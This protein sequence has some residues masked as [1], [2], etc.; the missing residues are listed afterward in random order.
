M[1]EVFLGFARTLRHAGVPATPDRVQ[2]ML[3]ALDVLHVTEPA[4]VYWA[5]RLTLCGEPDDLPIYDAAFAAYFGG[6][7]PT[8]G[9]SL[10]MNPTLPRVS[11][12]FAA[13]TG[14]GDDE[15]AEVLTLS[16]SPP[17]VLRHRDV[18]ELSTVERAEGRRLPALPAPLTAPRRSRRYRP[19]RRGAVDAHRTGRQA[20]RPEGEPARPDRSGPIPNPHRQGH[21][22]GRPLRT[23]S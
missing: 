19:A 23:A 17:A 18:A 4:D 1:I 22:T 8:A 12:P 2:A 7:A 9:R 3:T 5:G 11:V 21:V 14:D 6:Q 10:P 20:L 15:P 13:G 16:A